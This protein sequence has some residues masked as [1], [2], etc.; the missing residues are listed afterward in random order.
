MVP[1]GIVLLETY[2]DVPG[3]RAGNHTQKG[4]IQHEHKT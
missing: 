3:V 4:L 2:R 1:G